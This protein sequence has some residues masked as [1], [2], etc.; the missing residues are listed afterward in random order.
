MNAAM[1]NPATQRAAEGGGGTILANGIDIH[2]RRIGGDKP[3]LV[4]LHG[5][6]GSGA[7]LLPL[8]HA[9]E[10]RF[11][12]I[13]PDARGHGGS[14]APGN[15]YRYRDLASDVAALIEALKLEAPLLAGHSMGGMTAAVV[16]TEHK[17]DIRAV[18]L[19]DPTFI[20]PEWQ[21]E[22]YES[23]VATEHQQMVQMTRE[24]LLAQARLRNPA[25][26]EEMIQHL[27]DA[28]LHTRLRAFDILTPPNP[29][30]RELMKDIDV[31]VLLVAGDRGVVS[32]ETA[33]ELQRVDS[34]LRYELI[35]DAGHGLPYDKPEQLGAVV[36]AFLVQATAGGY[37]A[38]L[39]G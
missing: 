1:S 35:P 38:K 23:G 8:A 7:C 26:S 14:S 34:S 13:L 31:P 16:A 5:L 32:P 22:V 29:D 18:A 19:I 15:G 21:R 9:L 25:R 39:A 11:D 17:S 24:D 20:S 28:R 2:Y 36:S 37:G 6:I 27:V 30:W 3:P 4:I 33:W 10:D 12:V